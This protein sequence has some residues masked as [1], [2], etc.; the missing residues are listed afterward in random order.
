MPRAAITNDFSWSKS[1]H[2]KLQE[3]PRA[4]YFNYYRSWGGWEADAPKDVRE[5]YVLKKLANRYTWAGSIVHDSLRDALL[6]MRAGRAVEHS[7][8]ETRALG[9]MREDF[10]YSRGKSYW[11]QK[12]RKAFSGLVEHEY[13]E[14]VTDETWKQNAE[15]VRAA[16]GWFFASRWPA[17]AQGLKPAQWLEVEIGRAHV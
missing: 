1:R 5:L 14:P 3:C 4:Y 2:E 17:L 12:Y 11:T 10:R 6:D 8:V 16:L 13:G 7:R 15:T 9:L